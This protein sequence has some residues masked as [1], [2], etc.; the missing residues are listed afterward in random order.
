LQWP[1]SGGKA[2]PFKTLNQA[3]GRF[4][5]LGLFSLEQDERTLRERQIHSRR[6]SG[7]R[8]QISLAMLRYNGW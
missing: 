8:G 4:R 7:E 2:L 6:M 5:F 3:Q 1:K